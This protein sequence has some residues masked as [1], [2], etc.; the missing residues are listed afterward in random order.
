MD[1]PDIKFANST[2]DMRLIDSQ[3]SPQCLYVLITIVGIWHHDKINNLSNF[4]LNGLSKKRG[5]KKF[6]KEIQDMCFYAGVTL[7][8][9]TK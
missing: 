6:F 7:Q 4:S 1:T 3:L 5:C 8:P 2:K 9:I